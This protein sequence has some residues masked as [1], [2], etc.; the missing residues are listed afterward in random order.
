MT[1][2]PSPARREGSDTPTLLRSSVAVGGSPKPLS[3]ERR[4]RLQLRFATLWLK[5]R[6]S[7]LPP[8]PSVRYSFQGGAPCQVP[9]SAPSATRRKSS[10]LANDTALFARDSI[11]YASARMVSTTART[12]GRPATWH[13]RTTVDTEPKTIRLQIDADPRLAAAVGGAAR[14]LA[15]AAGI[16]NEA[17]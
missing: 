5:A 9:S 16:E 4:G 14:Y 15:D 2:V 11:K 13:L 8:Q 17:V 6:T 3:G 1:M 10:A 12:A 7:A